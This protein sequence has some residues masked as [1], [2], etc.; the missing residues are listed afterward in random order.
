MPFINGVLFAEDAAEQ[1][2]PNEMW[3]SDS[4]R[5][6]CNYFIA[7][8]T[9]AN[10]HKAAKA[11]LGF[12]KVQQDAGRRYLSRRL[13]A[14]Y[15]AVT[16][17]DTN[18]KGMP[19]MFARSI[20]RSEPTGAPQGVS[21]G[22]ASEYNWYKLLVEYT[23]LPFNVAA[24]DQVTAA[25]GPLAANATTGARA[26]PDEGDALR[27]GLEYS[28]Y[29]SRFV[30]DSNRLLTLRQGFMKYF[31][32]SADGKVVGLPMGVPYSQLS[33]RV[34]FV[35]H[36]VPDLAVPRDFINQAANTVN[37]AQFDIYRPETLLFK[38]MRERLMQAPFG[39]RLWE[40]SY[41]FDWL[42]NVQ[43]YVPTGSPPGTVPIQLGHNAVIRCRTDL[44]PT[45]QSNGLAY[46]SIVDGVAGR[47][48]FRSSDF[49]AFFRPDQ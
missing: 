25:A 4:A 31:K 5:V 32:H 2:S 8:G 16:D 26:L 44:A 21:A 14:A 36:D 24:D 43:T 13:P 46:E 39:G 15:P 37:D 19:Y 12:A 35:W 17:P 9:Q 29:V 28:R 10:R 23:T 33:A 48:P 34:M 38:T 20:P 49:S 6:M 27:R 7:N 40:I 18:P 42:P 30:D 1:P 11:L 41:I 3:A 22:G 45:D 47:T